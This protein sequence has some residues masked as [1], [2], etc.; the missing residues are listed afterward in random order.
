MNWSVLLMKMT[1]SRGLKMNWPVLLM[2]LSWSRVLM[3][4]AYDLQG[5]DISYH[6]LGSR[7]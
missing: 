4:M 5:Y 6:L 1:W 7:V 3:K 2:K